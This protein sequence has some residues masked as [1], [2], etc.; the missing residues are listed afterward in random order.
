MDRGTW[1]NTAHGVTKSQTQLSDFP[2][3]FHFHALEKEMATHSNILAWKQ[4][5]AASRATVCGVAQSWT[6][7][8]Q[9]SSSSSSSSIMSKKMYIPK[10]KNT[11]LLKNAYY[12]LRFQWA[13]IFLHSNTKDHWSEVTI[14]NKIIV[15]KLEIW[16]LSKCDTHMKKSCWENGTLGKLSSQKIWSV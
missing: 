13:I 6:L 14:T 16:E 11:S 10:F 2:F 5:R 7:L 3:T 9:L 15:K 12:H 4:G 8:K 1:Q